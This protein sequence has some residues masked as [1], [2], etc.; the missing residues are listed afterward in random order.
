MTREL[1]DF[2]NDLKKNNYKEWFESHKTRFKSVESSFKS[3]VFK[4]TQLLEQHDT[5]ERSKIFR[6]YRDIRFSKDKTPYKTQRSVNWIRAGI[7][8]RGSYYMKISPGESAIGVGFFK[9]EK[10]DLLRIRKELETDAQ[11]LR[12]IIERPEFFQVWN[13]LQGETL[14]TAPRDFDKSHPDIDL[15]KHKSFFFLKH[16]ND[17]QV[18]SPDFKNQVNQCFELARPYLDFM[19]SVLTT[20]LNGESIL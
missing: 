10:G 19:T 1:F 15:I 18:L 20:D 11:E 5:I 13:G 12:N 14:K 3:E 6:I 16:F 7:H 2:L 17:D 9:P 4:I 8:R